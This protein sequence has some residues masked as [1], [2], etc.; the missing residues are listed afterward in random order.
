[1]AVP[2]LL[3]RALFSLIVV[4]C[5][6]GLFYA[7]SIIDTGQPDGPAVTGDEAVE[8]RIPPPNSEILRQEAVGVDLRTGWTGV[9]QLNGVEIPLDQVDDANLAST[10]ELLFTVGEGK[11]VER[12][13]AGENC[14]TVVY[15]R[16]EDS[17]ADS[18]ST[19]WCFNVT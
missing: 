9:L 13:D 11:A 12:F 17:R 16:V 3:R 7:C 15:W 1:M 2:V 10:G 14:L 4:A 18:R 19:T 6:G 8:R 5:G